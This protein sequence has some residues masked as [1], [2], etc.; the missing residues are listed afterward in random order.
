MDA[1]SFGVVLWE[2]HRAVCAA[3]APILV[4]GVW[5]GKPVSLW[6]VWTQQCVRTAV[7]AAP[8][9]RCHAVQINFLVS[10]EIA[11]LVAHSPGVCTDLLQELEAAHD[12]EAELDWRLRKA[13][14]GI[15]ELEGPAR[16]AAALREQAAALTTELEVSLAQFRT[17]CSLS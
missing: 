7:H 13:Q 16:E 11:K 4:R 12:R 14:G 5:L 9:R 17:Q 3:G 15:R 2:D 6:G 10:S 8:A 1:A